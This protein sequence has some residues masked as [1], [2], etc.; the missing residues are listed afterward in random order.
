MAKLMAVLAA[1]LLTLSM[2]SCSS[3]SD[4]GSASNE[5]TTTL[6]A[7]KCEAALTAYNYNPDE[8][9]PEAVAE[10]RAVIDSCTRAQFDAIAERIYEEDPEG[11]FKYQSP[12]ELRKFL[13][14]DGSA[15]E[16][17]CK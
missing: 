14:G 6:D 16:A 10:F 4:S 11:A 3:G 8:G 7:S 9:G 13:C 17:F 1:V 15:P 2:A 12:S 5:T